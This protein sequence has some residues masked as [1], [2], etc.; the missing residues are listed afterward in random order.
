[1]RSL[2]ERPPFHPLFSV[3]DQR[4]VFDW[5]SDPKSKISVGPALAVCYS[6]CKWMCLLMQWGTRSHAGGAAFW[7]WDCN[8]VCIQSRAERASDSTWSMRKG[9]KQAFPFKA[10]LSQLKS[11]G[12]SMAWNSP[13]ACLRTEI[14]PGQLKLG[15]QTQI[16]HLTR[17]S[18]LFLL[19][20]PLLVHKTSITG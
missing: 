11:S 16:L 14:L 15:S 3:G 19:K 2:S 6:P 10:L 13:S 7:Y 4:Q 18:A 9:K 17:E 1:M 12:L 5:N 8:V 20:A